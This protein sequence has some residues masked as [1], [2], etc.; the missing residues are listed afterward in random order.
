MVV[1]DIILK[2]KTEGV[3]NGLFGILEVHSRNHG[4]FYFSTVENYEKKIPAGT[5]IINYTPSHKFGTNTLE[6]QGVDNRYGIRI[7]PG[8]RGIELEGCIAVGLACK[9]E[10]IKQQI[11][12][13]RFAVQQLE[14]MLHDKEHKITIKDIEKNGK[15]NFTKNSREHLTE[16]A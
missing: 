16:V 11:F 3:L 6:I 5:Y 7:H 12:Y 14:A 15:K 1:K 9:D 8:N 13:S 2:R 10:N 4:I